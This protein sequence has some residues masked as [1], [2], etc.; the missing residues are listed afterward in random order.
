MALALAGKFLRL[1]FPKIKTLLI[2]IAWLGFGTCGWAQDGT[3]IAWGDNGLG[4][5]A[6]PSGLSNVV[7]IA[8][9]EWHTLALKADGTVIAWGANNVG[10]GTVP[11][12]LSNVVAIAACGYHNLA[13]KADAT[14]MAW[15]WNEYGQTT[16]P[17][18]LSNVVV[19]KGGWSHSLALKADGTVIA[20]GRNQEGQASVPAGLNNVVAIA[21]GEYHNLALKADGT[22][23]AWGW[24]GVGQTT[25]PAGLNNVVA[26]AGGGLHSL[27]LKADGTVAAWGYN[28]V[29]QTDVPAG[30]SNVV[31]I[32]GGLEHNLA[33]KSDGTVVGW[34][35]NEA[36]ANN[37]CQYIGHP[38]CV[39]KPSGQIDI[40][41]GLSNVVGIAAGNFHSVALNAGGMSSPSVRLSID[42]TEAETFTL[43]FNTVQ[44][45]TYS[46]EMN[47]GFPNGTW[48]TLHT[49]LAGNG[50]PLQATDT[51]A[52]E[53][54]RRIYRV[55]TDPAGINVKNELAGFQRLL[56]RGNSDTA[57]S[58]PFLRPAADR[59][60]VISTAGNRIQVRGTAPWTPNQWVYD[61]EMQTNTCFLLICS[62]ASEG[63]SYTI[64]G[65]G[66]DSL[67]VDNQDNPSLWLNA[68]DQVAIVPYWTLGTI[69]PG[70]RGVHASSSPFIR[71]SEVRVPDIG[72]A[73]INLSVAATY[74]FRSGAWRRVG[75]DAAVKDHDVVRSDMFIWVRHNIATDTQVTTLGNAVG[76]K[77]AVPI[78]RVAGGKQDNILALPRPASVSLNASGLIESGAFRPSPGPFNRIDELFIF[79]NT[80]VAKNKSPA[81]TYYYWNGLWRKIGSDSADAG[82][83]PVFH[84]GTGVI[85]RSGA[86]ASSGLWL[87]NPAY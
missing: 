76:S 32:V 15:G 85:I 57:L 22:V 2:G 21:A 33:L 14:V 82:G 28:E 7:A 87:N 37:D 60:T 38:G 36:W 19:V 84:P 20:W 26:I 62:G 61:G 83:D 41:A 72:G 80:T 24:N 34:G 53:V 75:Q 12:G 8:A 10:Q 64:T 59:G 4:Q 58:I 48:Q 45:R 13:L 66:A 73:G 79:D 3:V 49:G 69:F 30:L 35:S 55:Q 44:G 47:D 51:T 17:A 78:I 31:A 56:L 16:V 68:G 42:A 29:G 63:K 39:R 52:S 5:T 77:W 67:T 23:T 54:S 43:R 25:V 1:M 81:G 74:Y 46:L 70:G 18:G 65:N 11:A 50:N 9:G 6:V 86:S 71:A 27:A 40:P